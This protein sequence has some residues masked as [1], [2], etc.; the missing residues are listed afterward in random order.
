MVGGRKSPGLFLSQVE[1]M[2]KPEVVGIAAKAI[3]DVVQRI[4]MSKKDR[5]NLEDWCK[6][7]EE[8]ERQ[9][10]AVWPS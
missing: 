5:Q 8:Y 2:M 9:A 3:R 10:K 7:L 6:L 1:Q 4:E